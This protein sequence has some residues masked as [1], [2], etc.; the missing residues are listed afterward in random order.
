VISQA[1]LL[2]EISLPR[3]CRGWNGLGGWAL[4]LVGWTTCAGIMQD[5]AGEDGFSFGFFYVFVGYGPSMD[6]F[7]WGK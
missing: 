6:V 4:W 5:F 3:S 2:P 1:A 7:F